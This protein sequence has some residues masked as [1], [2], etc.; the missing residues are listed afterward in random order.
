MSQAWPAPAKLNL[1]LHVLG[2]RSDGY[3]ELQTVFQFIDVSDDLDFAIRDDGVIKR[4]ST[5]SGIAPEDDLVVKA[6]RAL[7]G[8]SGTPLGADITVHKRIPMG[9]GLGGGSSDAATTLV[10]LNR[11]W[12]L[13]LDE[14]QLAAIGLALGADVPIFIYGHSAFAE[15]VGERFTA[16]TLDTPWYLVVKP[17]CEVATGAVFGAP[18][19]TRN[20]PP[21]TIADF[22][23]RTGRDMRLGNDCEP[24]VRAR[25]PQVAEAL[26]WLSERASTARLT[27]TGSCIFAAFA[28]REEAASR[29]A[30]LPARWQAFV[31]RGLNRSPLLERLAL[32]RS[33][34]DEVQASG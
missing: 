32:A 15:G 17:D 12:S 2:R 25:Y 23:S 30:E 19:L 29:L 11:L 24:V 10:A 1:F 6:A 3:H 8:H 16:V 9:G 22:L 5:A 33:A 31:T 26:E 7:R 27:G 28:T 20:T 13:D 18:E 4:R 14:Q 21:I 34:D